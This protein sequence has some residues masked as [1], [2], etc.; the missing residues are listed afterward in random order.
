MRGSSQREAEV[1]QLDRSIDDGTGERLDN[2]RDCLVAV[3]IGGA[4]VVV[5]LWSEA[6]SGVEG[7]VVLGE[8]TGGGVPDPGILANRGPG[9]EDGDDGVGLFASSHA[10]AGVKVVGDLVVEVADLRFDV[11]APG[12]DGPGFGGGP[13]AMGGKNS[14]RSGGAM[15]VVIITMSVTALKRPRSNTPEASPIWAKMSPTSPRAII[16][17]PITFLFPLNQNGA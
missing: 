14:L 3:A 10:G 6:A 4:V 8:A 5:G 2:V 17:T 12:Q 16:P 13:A 11:A 15:N 9:A 7:G 1:G